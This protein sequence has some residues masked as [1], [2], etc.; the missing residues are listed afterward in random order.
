M[1]VES[2]SITSYSTYSGL[3]SKTSIKPI[4]QTE[5]DQNLTQIIAQ[6][7]FCICSY[8]IYRYKYIYTA[9]NGSFLIELRPQKWN[10]KV[11]IEI[12][13]ANPANYL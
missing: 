5:S 9:E 11:T 12:F 3:T 13:P 7:A 4:A 6:I 8:R 2:K 1:L 10:W